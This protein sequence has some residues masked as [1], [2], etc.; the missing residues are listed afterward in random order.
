MRKRLS[1]RLLSVILTLAI[2]ATTVLGCLMT[3]SADNSCYSFGAAEVNE[4]MTQATLDVTFT[5][6]ESLPNGFFAGAFALKEVDANADDYLTVKSITA[7]G[8]NIAN[9]GAYYTFDMAEAKSTVTFTLT[10]GFSNGTASKGKTY[11]VQL[12]EVELAYSDSEYYV[13]S[14]SGPVAKISTECEHQ[15]T[16]VGTPLKV[17]EANNYSVY[18]KSVCTICGEEF[19]MQFVPTANFGGEDA[20]DEGATIQWDGTKVAPTEGSGT[21]ADPYIISEVSHLAYITEIGP[22]YTHGKY[23]KVADGIKNIVLQKAADA[24]TLIAIDSAEDAK[25]YLSSLSGRSRW[26]TGKYDAASAFCGTFDGNGATIYGLSAETSLNIS[27]FGSIGV[28]AEFKNLNIKNSFLQTGWYAA[29]L[30]HITV[31]YTLADGTAV[32]KGTVKIHDCTFAQNYL[33]P[34]SGVNPGDYGNQCIGVILGQTSSSASGTG[35]SIKN[36]LTYDNITFYELTQTNVSPLIGNLYS[37]PA[38]ASETETEYNELMDCIFLDVPSR[39]MASENNNFLSYSNVQSVFSDSTWVQEWIDKGWYN[40]AGADAM[41]VTK[42]QMLGSNAITTAAALNWGTDWLVGA[43]GELP[44]RTPLNYVSDTIYWDGANTKTAPSVGSGT[45]T[46]PYIISTVAELAYISGQGRDNYGITDGKYYKIADGIKNIVMQPYAYAG[47]IMAL[48]SASDVKSYFEANSANLKQWLYYGWEASTFCGN[49]DFNNATVYGIYQV[50]SSNAGLFSNIDAGAVISNLAIKNSYITSASSGA[51]YQASVLAAVTNGNSYGKSQSGFIWVKNVE[52]ANNYVYNNSTSHDRS[53]VVVGASS[54]ILYFDSIYVH[55]NDATYGSGVN[56]PVWSNSNNSAL[57]NPDLAIP[58][59]LEIVTDGNEEERYY[60]MIRNSIILGADPVDYA[61]AK[62]SRFNDP[63]CFEGVY[64]DCDI[65]TKTFSD[66]KSTLGAYEYMIKQVSASAITGGNAQTEMPELTWGTDWYCGAYGELPTLATFTTVGVNEKSTAAHK[67]YGSSVTYNDDGTFDFNLHFVPQYEGIK[68]TL[69]VG[70]KDVSKFYKLTATESSYRDDLGDN[71]LMFTLPNISARDID[72]VWLPTIVVE[73]SAM[74]EWGMTQSIALVDNAKGVLEGDYDTADKK[75]SAALINYGETAKAALS[76]TKNDYS[77]GEGDLLEFGQYLKDA[78]SS[79]TY[80]DSVLVDAGETGTADDPIIIDNAEE[81]VYLAKASGDDTKGKYYK[82]ADGIAYFDLSKGNLDF[83]KGLADNLA[84]IQASGKNHS[85]NTPGF[86]GHFDGNGVT[87]YGAW[88]SNTSPSTYSGLFSCTYGEV[89][90]KNVHVKLASFTAKNAVGGIIGYHNAS[91]LCTVTVENCSITE[92][93]LETT[94]TGY[95]STVAAIIGWGNSAPAKREANDGVDYNGDGDTSDTIYQ[96]VN[97]NVKNCYVELDEKYFI[98]KAEDGTEESGERA[99]HGGV[100]GGA[101]SN[102]VMVSDCIVIGVKPYSTTESTAYNDIQHTGHSNNFSNVYTDQTVGDAIYVGGTSGSTQAL[103]SVMT[104]LTKDELTGIN[105]KANMPTLNWDTVWTTTSGYP[106]F[107]NKDY[108]AP[109][110]GRTISYTGSN[111]TIEAVEPTT[112]SG[113]AADPIIINTVQELAWVVGQ[114][115]TNVAKTQKYFKVADGITSIVLQKPEYAADI[116][117]LG[118]AAQTKAYFEANASNMVKWKNYGWEGSTFAGNIDFNGATVYGAYMPDSANNAALISNVDGGAVISNL[119]IKNSYFKSSVDNYQV[120]AVFANTNNTSYALKAIGAIWLNGI[121]VANNYLYNPS[122]SHDRSGVLVG[123]ASD[124]VYIDNTLVYGNDATYGDSVTMPIVSTANNSVKVSSNPIIPDGLEVVTEGTDPMYRNMVRNSMFFGA[125]PY[126]P[127]QGIG[128]RF[129]AAN[130]YVNVYTD[131][132]VSK[133]NSSEIT[134][135][136]ADKAL[137]AAAQTNMP[138]LDW[139]IWYVG[140]T[141]DMPALKPAGDMPASFQTALDSI[142]FDTLDTV[143]SGTEYYTSG[144]MLFGVYQTA[145]SLKANPYMSF[146]FAF[147]YD[148]K[149]GSNDYKT[150]RDKITIKF[151]YTENGALVSKE[152]Q[153]PAYVEGEDLNEDGW[154]NTA[155]NG[156][157]HTFKAD[158]IPVEALASGI[159][160]E[161]SYDGGEWQDFGTYSVEGLGAQFENANKVTPGDYYSTRV[162]AAKALLFYAQ[163]IAAR[164]GA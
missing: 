85:G 133:L 149:A 11:K 163:A 3:V 96:N 4:E 82:V 65:A 130:C 25:T 89:S 56:M 124:I 23:F 12:E 75:V 2:C 62:G 116:M 94:G 158:M 107:I 60:N 139:S 35:V 17:D 72:K 118:S 26:N 79:S 33:N 135:V 147:G 110:G 69:Y 131:M 97:Y 101:G 15:I 153:V 114:T 146:A 123:A 113:T 88:G 129:N 117:A 92:S 104:Q 68:A 137:G 13:Q 51:N 111:A 102:A 81:F 122:T 95:A 16:V 161:A 142:T 93:H 18:E 49:I 21:E 128:S 87:V 1:S 34:Q 54:D 66:G 109:A 74:L 38:P 145:L 48:D 9:E 150:N 151:T 134:V 112:G 120:G 14:V 53:G 98:S 143:G 157:F 52:I 83:N 44:S 42:E 90:I 20:A 106:T 148:S 32:S 99:I 47:D 132:D 103:S 155:K 37:P 100:V 63:H 40:A 67:L 154:T 45:K 125:Y 127:A 30:A 121:I 57:V 86:Q 105:A 138:D 84:K 24:E 43:A 64:T 31:G 50:S 162:D 140:A 80:Y 36:V 108:E 91:E 78:G 46:D 160:V 115:P 10:F 6:P 27:L 8:V 39:L 58:E 136:T 70:T 19:G 119:S 28:N 61:Q 73:G 55:D 59:G 29:T 152:V 41:T 22:D 159:K 144:S 5:A 7:D 71:A 126:D 141:G 164:Y 76:I 77:A 156:R